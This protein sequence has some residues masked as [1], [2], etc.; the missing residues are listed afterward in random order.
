MNRTELEEAVWQLPRIQ[1]SG[2]DFAEL[3]SMSDSELL[4]LLD[5]KKR[6]KKE[7]PKREPVKRY[8]A[9]RCVSFEYTERDGRLMR[10]ET[11]QHQNAAGIYFTEHVA[12][13]GAQVTFN[14]RRVSSSLVLHWV[15][16]GELVQR[17]PRAAKP[18]RGL[19]RVAGR[20]VHLG[21]FATKEERD[22]ACGLAKLG[23]FP[24]GR[25]NA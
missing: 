12:P 9:P 11:W 15:R 8:P 1:E 2:I 20:L 24:L 22:A 3:E 17:V 10:L 6:P 13:T 25:N 18:F 4:A 7:K 14:G 16:T 23:I 21:Y 19:V 5:H